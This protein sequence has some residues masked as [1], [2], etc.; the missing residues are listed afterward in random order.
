MPLNKIKFIVSKKEKFKM[1]VL[2][3]LETFLGKTNKKFIL[4]GR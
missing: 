3:F 4:S 2:M 1:K